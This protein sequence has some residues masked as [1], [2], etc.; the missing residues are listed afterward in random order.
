MNKTISRFPHGTVTAPPSKSIMHRAVICAALGGGDFTLPRVSDDIDATVR[1]MRA[2]T[3]TKPDLTGVGADEDDE[4][5][6][7][8][9]RLRASVVTVD[10]GESGSTLRFL[11][12]IAL[13]MRSVP[14]FTMTAAAAAPH[15][16]FT[17]R[18]RLLE[19]PMKPFLDELERHGAMVWQGPE[20]ITISGCLRPGD[21]ELHGDV[22]SQ[23]VSGLL[24]A[25]PLLGGSSRLH[26]ASPLESAAYVDLTLD[27]LQNAGIEIERDGDDFIVRGNQ[28]YTAT[29]VTAEGD[30]SQAAFFLAA[31]ALGR[32]VRC[33]GLSLDSRQGDAQIL[34]ILQE[35]GF[36]I[37][38]SNT[39]RVLPQKGQISRRNRRILPIDLDV[40]GIPDLVPPLA[41]LLCTADGTSRLYNAA[42]LRMKESDRL[43]AVKSAL[44]S[45]G[46]DIEIE[47]DALVIYGVS[48]LLGGTVDAQGDH[49]IAMMAAVA[50]LRADK[51]VTIK[52]AECVSKSYPDFWRDFEVRA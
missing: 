51:P 2:L 6:A 8:A 29:A 52:G 38:L 7:E 27:A 23:F 32:D 28:R 18:G 20:S 44:N 47:D 36:E 31:A 5:L 10:C 45:I 33:A 13:A 41:A 17:G 42:R 40:S 11:I 14:S 46:A 26:L 34:A 12:P 3:A 35:L 22:S 25:L 50:A 43:E 48:G 24:F 39:I 21:Y 19:R 4:K 49:R 30:F 37:E 9:A 15:I 16:V 1:C